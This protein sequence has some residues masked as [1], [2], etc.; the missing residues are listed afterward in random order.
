MDKLTASRLEASAASREA[1]RGGSTTVAMARER[2]VRVREI[3][4]TVH[5]NDELMIPTVVG[6]YGGAPGDISDDD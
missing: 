5:Q 4:A 1:S 2:R 6:E 3:R